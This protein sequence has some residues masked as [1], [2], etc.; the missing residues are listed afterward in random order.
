MRGAEVGLFR[1]FALLEFGDFARVRG[2][3]EIAGHAADFL[4]VDAFGAGEI[5]EDLDQFRIV[6]RLHLVGQQFVAVD[7]VDL[8]LIGDR[9]QIVE[10]GDFR[11]AGGSCS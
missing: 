3:V 8:D 2:D 4:A 6:V 5:A 10:V 9:Q 7:R 11:G 1:A